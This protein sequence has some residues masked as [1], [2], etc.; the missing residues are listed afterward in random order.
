MKLTS[1]GRERILKAFDHIQSAIEILDGIKEECERL[2]ERKAEAGGLVRLF[3]PAD[4][5]IASL[6]ETVNDAASTLE[7]TG[8]Y[9]YWFAKT[10]GGASAPQE[11]P[12][13]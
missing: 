2:K 9:L 8:T 1:N 4:D 13:A 11:M 12:H 10:D 6:E 3:M 7:V 5:T